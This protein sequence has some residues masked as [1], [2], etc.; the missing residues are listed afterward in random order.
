[1]SAV[2]A[3]R[4]A[5][6]GAAEGRIDLHR[7]YLDAATAKGWN[8][9]PGVRLVHAGTGKNATDLLL[10]IDAMDL[11]PSGAF[12]TVVIASSDGD[13]V[14][15]A[16]RLRERGMRVVGMSEAAKK[17][18]RFSEAC[19]EFQF[20]DSAPPTSAVTELDHN[21]R[22]V[23]A[24]NSRNGAGMRL[25]NLNGEMRPRFDIKISELPERTWRRYLSARP[26]LFDLDPKSKGTEAFVR[27]LP[28]GF[29]T[30]SLTE[31]AS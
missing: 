27:F 2:H 15:L 5:Q 9:A 21:I 25:A 22:T 13:F 31:T 1:M 28:D 3:A 6:R 14:H 11:C 24:Q 19:T 8:D 20:L 12:D 17:P 16:T 26:H 7:A 10:A 29:S 23:I 30:V 4:I 18:S